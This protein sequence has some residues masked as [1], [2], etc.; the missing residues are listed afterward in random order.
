MNRPTFSATPPN[1]AELSFVVVATPFYT[2]STRRAV[3]VAR[4]TRTTRRTVEQQQLQYQ[5]QQLDPSGLAGVFGFGSST[6]GGGGGGGDAYYYASAPSG[7]L[8]VG[9]GST[10]VGGSGGGYSKR[11]PPR[12][13][14]ARQWIQVRRPPAPGV[15]FT[16][17]AWV[18]VDQLTEAERAIH[19][20]P[21]T[22]D[23]AALRADTVVAELPI[24]T[25]VALP[26]A[27]A[28]ADVQS[29]VA[30]GD[31]TAPTTLAANPDTS[32][33]PAGPLQQGLGDSVTDEP[34]SHA[35]GAVPSAASPD[36]TTA[37]AAA[38][39]DGLLSPNDRPTKRARFA[40]DGNEPIAAEPLGELSDR[41][42][43][44]PSATKRQDYAADETTKTALTPATGAASSG[45]PGED[46]TANPALLPPQPPPA[47]ASDAPAVLSSSDRAS[48]RK[49]D[50]LDTEHSMGDS[51]GEAAHD[52]DG[53]PP[54]RPRTSAEDD[55]SP[56]A[57]SAKESDADAGA[58]AGARADAQ[59]TVATPR[60]DEDGSAEAAMEH[61]QPLA[62]E[63][64]HASASVSGMVEGVDGQP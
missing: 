21:S 18:P 10:G 4:A 42:S 20:P 49:R 54:K 15:G 47:S 29:A 31:A 63:N 8:V 11:P 64:V 56:V 48:G 17:A 45:L 36:E 5:H 23:E 59:M 52:G 27:V 55:D 61:Q 26:L 40:Q 24:E 28:P 50:I 46:I 13:K 22:S 19:L 41:T 12:G 1:S 57:A 51:G 33:A 38:M 39:E 62:N 58:S 6:S 25:S 9:D 2:M 7:G 3:R 44:E 35:S 53:P 43:M 60:G 30:S 14:P 37:T 32:A 16:V 34:S